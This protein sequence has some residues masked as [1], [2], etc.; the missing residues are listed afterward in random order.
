MKT[1]FVRTL[2]ALGFIGL[3]LIFAMR[4]SAQFQASTQDELK[5]TADTK[6]PDAAAVVLNYE[7]K[8]DNLVG[9]ESVYARIKI[10]KESA[11]ELATVHLPYT[12]WEGFGGIA[13]IS[14]RTIHADGSIVP[15]N[16]KPEGRWLVTSFHLARRSS[17]RFAEA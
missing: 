11:K 13:A 15:M 3:V 17:R 10:L 1:G 16:V 14:G 4:G 7:K 5:M 9:Y 2:K 8:T 6:Y 12:K